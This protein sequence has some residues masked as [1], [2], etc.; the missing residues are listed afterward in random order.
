MI[1][2]LLLLLQT[3]GS[4][5]GAEGSGYVRAIAIYGVRSTSLVSTLPSVKCHS[6]VQTQLKPNGPRRLR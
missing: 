2:L 6:S 3:Q 4:V 5:C 1:P